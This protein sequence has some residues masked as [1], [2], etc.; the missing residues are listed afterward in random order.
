MLLGES[1]MCYL[2]HI[3]VREQHLWNW[4]P[5]S[6]FTWVQWRKLRPPC[7]WQVLYPLNSL[8]KLK[9]RY[10]EGS[11]IPCPLIR[12]IVASSLLGPMISIGMTSWPFLQIQAWHS[13]WWTITKSKQNTCSL[14]KSHA[15]SVPLGTSYQA[16]HEVNVLL[17]LLIN[18]LPKKHPLYLLALWK[19][20]NSE[21]S[22]TSIPAW[23]S[24][25][26]NKKCIL[27]SAIGS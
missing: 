5:P 7:L 20:T 19:L 18:V 3:K 22:S 6:D 24:I 21:K 26:Y 2:T 11:L 13:F 27:L 4:F 14:H 16:D 12:T 8:T 23:F 10:S 1:L 25:F 17:V 15:T 9:D